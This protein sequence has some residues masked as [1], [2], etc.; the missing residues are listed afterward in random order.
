MNIILL[1][2][3]GAGKGTQAKRIEERHGVPQLSTGDMLRAAVKSGSEL[4]QQA[5][6]VMDAGELM[7]DELMV[8]MIEERI[9][10]PDC[11]N[12]FILDGFPRTTAQAHALDEMLARRGTK[13]DAVIELKVDDEALVE[14]ITGRYSCAECGAGYHDKFHQPQTAGVCDA[15]GA[16]T[17]KRRD[18]DNEETVRSRLDAY[19]AQTAPILP[20]YEGKGMLWRVDGMADIDEV[21]RQI[22]D[23][24]KR[25]GAAKG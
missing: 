20:Y 3:P 21:T 24:L 15:C 23:V 6:K 19:H 12:G 22:E 25:S 1:G 17:F 4:G 9:Q 16:T 7:P 10:Q 8:K 14:R 5:K 2:P 13:L 11:Q 18:D